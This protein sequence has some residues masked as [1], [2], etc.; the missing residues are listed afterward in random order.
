[1]TKLRRLSLIG[2]QQPLCETIVDCPEPI[3]SEVLV[4]IERCGVCHSDLHM[5]DGYFAL[6]DGKTLDVREGRTL[7]V[8]VH[9]RDAHYQGAKRLGHGKGY[10]YAHDF[11]EHFVVQDYLGASKLY[12]EP[13]EQG[14]EK[15]IKERLERWREE[16]KKHAMAQSKRENE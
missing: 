10:Q 9:L 4:R 3:G 11:P 16:A 14:V 5:Q 1:M 13:T 15:K 2:Y 8:P 7:P 12:Y 6:A